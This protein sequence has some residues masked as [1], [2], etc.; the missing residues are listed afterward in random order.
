M[1]RDVTKATGVGRGFREWLQDSYSRM[2][3]GLQAW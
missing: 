1:Y 3:G 2:Q